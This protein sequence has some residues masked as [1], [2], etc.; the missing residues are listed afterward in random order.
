MPEPQIARRCLA[1]G[2]SIRVPANFC[3]ECGAA[4]APKPD[5][6]SE[7]RDIETLTVGPGT[8]DVTDTS[9]VGE[10]KPLN[11]EQ[12]VTPPAAVFSSPSAARK[13]PVQATVSMVQSTRPAPRQVIGEDG[14]NRVEKLRQ[15]SGA[16]ID[17]AAYDPSL[18]F[19]L[20]A[21]VLFVLFLVLLLLSEFLT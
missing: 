20:V 1:C 6:A 7:A 5:A 8:P 16:M 18:R 19:V 13:Q 11:V 9:T 4:L 3:P 10:T 15:I 2:V 21:A 17:E 14:L 12:M